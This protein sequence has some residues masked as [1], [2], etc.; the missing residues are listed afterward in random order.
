MPKKAVRGVLWA[1]RG[2][3]TM[4]GLAVMMAVV[5]G[6]GTTALAAVPGDPLRLAKTNTINALT[7]LTGTAN[8]ALLKIDNASKGPNATALELSTDPK[9][10]PMKVDSS[11]KV[12]NL[13]ADLL[14]GK[15]PAAFLPAGAKARDSFNSDFASFAG[16]AQNADFAAD[17]NNLDGKDSTAFLPVDAYVKTELRVGDPNKTNLGVVFCDE[18]D[19]L[20]SGGHGLFDGGAGAEVGQSEP[21]ADFDSWRVLWTGDG[22]IRV[23]V[24]CADLPPLHED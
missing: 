17:A 18:G 19:A 12:G 13:N 2:T 7:Q 16:R 11:T 6:V 4:V 3:A 14:D 23:T 15:D 9:R 5:L 20:L 8:S 10:P 21:D 1:A 22:Q 24:L